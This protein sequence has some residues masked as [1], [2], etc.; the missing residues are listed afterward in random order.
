M[1]KKNFYKQMEIQEHEKR[2]ASTNSTADMYRTV[3]NHFKCFNEDEEFDLKD[4]TSDR[5]QGFLAWLQAK[6]LRVNTL[7]SYISNL[8]AMYNRACRGWKSK[9]TESPFAEV[10]LKRQ[11]TRKRAVSVEVIEKI[12]SLELDEEPEKKQAVDLALFSFMA[13]GTPFV[14]IAHLTKDNLTD[15]GTVLSYKRKKTGVLVQIEISAGMQLLIDRYSRPDAHYLFPILSEYTTHEQYKYLLSRQNHYLGEV[16]EELNLSEPLT[17][18]TFR[19]SWA[20]EAYHRDVPIGIISQALGHSSEKMT[21]I[22]LSAF[23]VDKVGEANKRVSGKIELLLGK[24]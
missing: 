22:Y 14:D 24:L 8:R 9:P 1:K 18:Y 7:N 17:T 16:S 23:D 13:C 4:M 21:R 15:N 19:H 11:E 5:V 3:R 6:G 12:A 10:R 2:A 20:S